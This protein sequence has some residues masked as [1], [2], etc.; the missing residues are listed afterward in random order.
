MTR[1]DPVPGMLKRIQLVTGL[2]TGLL[3]AAT[4]LAD[5][6]PLRIDLSRLVLPA[7]LLG[8]VAP[9]LGYR[10]YLWRRDRLPREAGPEARCRAFG[11]ATALALGAAEVIA[12][13]GVVTFA[14]T[15][16]LSTLL[17]VLTY[18]ILASAIWPTPERLAA[19]ADADV[20][21]S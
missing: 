17:G 8:L 6:V 1:Q 18:V 12:A 10:L 9:V 14:A 2:R 21:A 5:L 11:R 3:L 19:F 20:D 15:G 13:L 4:A 7:G 16:V